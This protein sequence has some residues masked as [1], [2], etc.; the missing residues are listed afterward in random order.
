MSTMFFIKER[1]DKLIDCLNKIDNI[2]Y[3]IR[4]EDSSLLDK[5]SSMVPGVS[6]LK[7][8]D[9][10][11]KED[12]L[13]DLMNKN[14]SRVLFTVVFDEDTNKEYITDKLIKELKI[15]DLKNVIYNDSKIFT[16]VYIDKNDGSVELCTYLELKYIST[17]S[18]KIIS[19]EEKPITII[20]NHID[21][22][23]YT[24]KEYSQEIELLMNFIS[25]FDRY[26]LLND[27]F[28]NLNNKDIAAIKTKILNM[29]P[30]TKRYDYG[31]LTD[32]KFIK[33]NSLDCIKIEFAVLTNIIESNF[34]KSV[35]VEE[36]S[37]TKNNIEVKEYEFNSYKRYYLGN[38]DGPTKPSK[39][40][41]SSIKA[42]T[43]DDINMILKNLDV[44]LV[45]DVKTAKECVWEIDKLLQSGHYTPS[46]KDVL[47]SYKTKFNELSSIIDS[48]WFDNL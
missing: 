7:F 41:K 46:E 48:E 20:S 1:T 16:D 5:V 45:N 33:N 23:T 8:D 3:L 9:H 29:F 30:D 36:V 21:P 6:N 15:K 24:Y 35:F 13:N 43:L 34:S 14:L 17:K 22:K 2:C 44:D 40:Y 37:I 12:T 19:L 39:I 27:G 10:F 31:N 28:N 18:N 42:S 26:K 25:E 38:I 47:I 32:I 11:K 4:N